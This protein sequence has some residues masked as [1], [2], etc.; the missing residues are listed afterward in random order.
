MNTG[1]SWESSVMAEARCMENVP[2]LSL[3]ARAE[4]LKRI[5]RLMRQ[6][7]GVLGEVSKQAG[8][9]PGTFIARRSKL[10][11][12]IVAKLD[13]QERNRLRELAGPHWE[14]LVTAP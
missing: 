14:V 12:E 4:R 9:A 6:H 10:F 13:E 1:S 8:V 5:A 7:N 3:S 11:P 2:D